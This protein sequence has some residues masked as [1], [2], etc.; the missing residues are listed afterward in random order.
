MAETDSS[1]CPPVNTQNSSAC[2]SI[3]LFSQRCSLLVD[4]LTVRRYRGELDALDAALG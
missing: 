3:C 4:I 2:I 1:V